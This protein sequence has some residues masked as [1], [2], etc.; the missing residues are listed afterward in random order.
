MLKE[1]LLFFVVVVTICVFSLYILVFCKQLF[2]V[3]KTQ[4]KDVEE[5]PFFCCNYL[6]NFILNSCSDYFFCVRQ[7]LRITY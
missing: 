3:E 4:D 5:G 7:Y 1:A 6:C 2:A